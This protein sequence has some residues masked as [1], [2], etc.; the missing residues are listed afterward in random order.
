[1]AGHIHGDR[2]DPRLIDPKLPPAIAAAIARAMA[3]PPEDRHQSAD[4][5]RADLE[6][7]LATG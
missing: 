5:L 3:I 6:R 2:P 1:M 7:I 4:A